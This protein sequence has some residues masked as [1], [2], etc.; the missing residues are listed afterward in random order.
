MKTILIILTLFFIGCATQGEW[1][2]SKFYVETPVIEEGK[3]TEW[4]KYPLEYNTDSLLLRP[5]LKEAE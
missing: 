1:R 2:R 4:K 3:V 5:V